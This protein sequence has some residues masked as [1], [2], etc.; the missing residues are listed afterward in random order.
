MENAESSRQMGG[1]S[2]ERQA[3]KAGQQAHAAIDPRPH[4]ED[5]CNYGRPRNPS[6]IGPAVQGGATT[7]S[8]ASSP[9]SGTPIGP[10]PLHG[11]ASMARS[12]L[13]GESG[14]TSPS[15]ELSC[16]EHR[17]LNRPASNSQAVLSV[18]PRAAP[19]S[20]PASWRA[21]QHAAVGA[22]QCA[23]P[24]CMPCGPSDPGRTACLYLVAAALRWRCGRTLVCRPRETLVA[25]VAGE[26]Q[27]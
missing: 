4:K 11:P 10:Q 25:A 16:S 19:V 24:I 20:V 3:E 9:E 26:N 21:T 2:S 13:I 7:Q 15:V 22:D 27:R 14:E 23:W 18:R 1:A 6:F 8:D 5:D 17:E 12:G